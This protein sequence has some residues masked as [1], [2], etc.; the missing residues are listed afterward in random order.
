MKLA[1]KLAI[2]QILIVAILGLIGFVIINASFT[3]IREQ[4]IKDTIESRFRIITDDIVTISR[5]TI[6]DAVVFVSLPAVSQAFETAAN[7]DIEGAGFFLKEELSPILDNYAK[8]TGEKLNLHFRMA[9]GQS[10]LKIRDGSATSASNGSREANMGSGS[11]TGLRVE[12]GEY[13]LY[14]MIRVYSDDGRMLGSIEVVKDFSN[15]LERIAEDGKIQIALFSNKDMPAGEFSKVTEFNDQDITSLVSRDMLTRGKSSVV[16][17]NH[18]YITLATLPLHDY[19]N[20][21]VGVLVLALSTESITI[22]ATT[23]AIILAVVVACMAVVPTIAL[24]VRFRSLAVKPLNLIKSK[25][26]DIAEDRADLDERIKIKQRD[27][28]GDLVMWFNTLTAKVDAIIKERQEMAHW[29]KSILDTIPLLISVQD[30]NMKW[31]F[32]NKEAEKIIGRK[33]EEVIGMACK[34]WGLDI[35]GTEQCSVVTA[36]QGH[37]KTFLTHEGA[38]YHVDVTELKNL[39]N[40]VVGF[41]EVMQDFTEWN[42]MVKQRAD[43]EARDR[44]KSEFLANISHEMRT[45]LNAIMGMTR[46]GKN[47]TD[48]ERIGYTFGKIE[49]ASSHLL[50][51]IDDILDVA[52]IESGELELVNEEFSFRD[53][54]LK[55][56]K[57][58]WAQADK[59]KQKFNALLDENVPLLLY[60]D[61]ERLAQVITNLLSN[62]VKFTPEEGSVSIETRLIEKK[63]GQCTLRIDVKDTGIGISDKQKEG[64]FRSFNQAEDGYSR[65]HGGTGLGLSIAKNIIELMGGELNVKSELGKGSVFTITVR[66]KCGGQEASAKIE[67]KVD[68]DFLGKNI[69][70]AEDVDINRE[71]VQLLLEPTQVNIDFAE[72][73]VEAV[74]IFCE[75]PEKYDLIFMDLQMPEMDGFEAARQIRSLDDPKAKNIPIVALTA[76]VSKEDIEKSLG[77]GM[78]DHL[79]KP[80]DFD[81]IMGVLNRYLQ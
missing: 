64:L 32:L 23:A 21:Q 57:E 45:P 1:G 47:S 4:Y 7:G 16:Y 60:G 14:G 65:K 72:N 66:L 48:A 8:A 17:E 71:I 9:D 79:G 62:A 40:E 12:N 35:C 76:N 30:I 54:L 38:S 70:L 61:E 15:I 68:N 28:I 33:R 75:A 31:T 51:V 20:E 24:A 77:V 5:K 10:L 22:V 53:M 11:A 42:I 19:Q 13:T 25:I 29:Y 80:I 43:A 49:E 58:T 34:N 52:K 63:D 69:L 39:Q 81:K 73:G 46:V 18:G 78:N 3:G 67:E 55:V 74:R 6:G 59:K 26:R 27:E 44:A 41:I 2:P 50:V 37:P 56:A 36:R